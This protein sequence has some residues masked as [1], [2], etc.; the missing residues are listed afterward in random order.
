MRRKDLP[1]GSVLLRAGGLRLL[2]SGDERSLLPENVQRALIELRRS[3][4][5]VEAGSFES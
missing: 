5:A 2:C 1:A 4:G 3:L